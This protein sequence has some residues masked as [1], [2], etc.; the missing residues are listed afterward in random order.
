MIPITSD[1]QQESTWSLSREVCLGLWSALWCSEG[2]GNVNRKWYK[3]GHV[4][5][6]SSIDE[7]HY[8]DDQEQNQ[9]SSDDPH[10]VVFPD[11]VFECLP[12]RGEPQEGCGR[13]AVIRTNIQ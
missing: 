13:A 5:Y 3:Q 9:Y 4:T 10:L 2:C 7:D 1:L 12:G 11:D 8:E 6:R